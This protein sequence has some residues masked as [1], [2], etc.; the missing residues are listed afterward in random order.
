M[1][2]PDPLP[3]FRLVV[4][5]EPE[6]RVESKEIRFLGKDPVRLRHWACTLG[7]RGPEDMWGRGQSN[8]EVRPQQGS[9]RNRRDFSQ[10]VS[11]VLQEA[12]EGI[13]RL[14]RQG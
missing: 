10:W 13:K 2:A 3:C 4:G 6:G 14:H 7:R 8:Q 12:G 11:A 1:E 9:M 5:T